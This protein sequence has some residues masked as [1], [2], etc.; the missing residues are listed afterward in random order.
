[1][2][3]YYETDD[4]ATIPHSVDVPASHARYPAEIT[5]TPRVWAEEVYNI[6]HWNELTEGGHFVGMEVPDLFM[7]DVRAFFSKVR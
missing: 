1:M 5:K 2:R 6:A 3:L 7:E 4:R